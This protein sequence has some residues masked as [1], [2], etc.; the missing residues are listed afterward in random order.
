MGLGISDWLNIGNTVLGA[1]SSNKAAN[2][3]QGASQDAIAEL[4]RQYDT[5]RAD[6][7]P[8]QA[9]GVKALGN[10]SDPNA[11][12]MASPDYAFRRSEGQRDLG[13]SFAARGGAFSG[14]ALRALDQ[15][16]QSL[17]SGE[18]GNWWNRQAGLAG[19]G[20]TANAQTGVLGQNTANNVA[21]NIVGAGDARASGIQNTAAILGGGARNFVGN[22]L[23]RNAPY[24]PYGGYSPY[25][26]YG[27]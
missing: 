22:Y 1:V 23:Y 6:Q 5:T 10:L 19:V 11:N 16:N 9:A 25:Q 4:R 24:Q 2:V 3:Q 8:Y 14:N 18:F 26:G 12:F 13:N 27:G 17:A 7:A 20:Q 15:Y 21:N